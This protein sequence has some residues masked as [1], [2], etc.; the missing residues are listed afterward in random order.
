MGKRLQTALSG[1]RDIKQKAN[2]VA[3]E[4]LVVAWPRL[5]VVGGGGLPDLEGHGS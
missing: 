1:S 3:Q 2:V 4:E 5:V